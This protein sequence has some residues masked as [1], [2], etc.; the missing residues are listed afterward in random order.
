[1][2]TR[3]SLRQNEKRRCFVRVT[4][5]ASRQCRLH[6]RRR[7]VSTPCLRVLD[8]GRSAAPPCRS[9]AAQHSRGR[10]CYAAVGAASAAAAS[11]ALERPSALVE[12]QSTQRQEQASEGLTPQGFVQLHPRAGEVDA[13]VAPAKQRLRPAPESRVVYRDTPSGLSEYLRP[14][15]GDRCA[16]LVWKKWLGRRLNIS[17]HLHFSGARPPTGTL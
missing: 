14:K 8:A 4:P 1:V 13:P 17:H 5:I 16:A 6:R 15:R 7:M 10:R 9:Q 12:E 3:R 11:V 2:T